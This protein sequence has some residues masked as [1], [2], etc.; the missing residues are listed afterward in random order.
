MPATT[1]AGQAAMTI[2][3]AASAVPVFKR[4]RTAKAIHSIM[5]RKYHNKEAIK[6]AYLAATQ[7]I[8]Y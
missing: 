3:H 1:V 7:K 4:R 2:G 6:L 8:M 5:I